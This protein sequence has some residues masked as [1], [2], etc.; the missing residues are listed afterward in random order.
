MATS[1]R[2]G[3]KVRLIRQDLWFGK[4]ATP[5]GSIGTVKYVDDDGVAYVSFASEEAY[6]N[7]ENLELVKEEVN[8]S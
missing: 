2:K 7:D 1:F 4:L 6:V 8:E 3:D 5:I